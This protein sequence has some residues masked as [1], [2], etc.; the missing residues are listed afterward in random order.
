M[1]ARFNNNGEMQGSPVRVN[2]Q[3]GVAT[4]W[5]GDQPSLAIGEDG[6]VYVVW[7]VAF[8]QETNTDQIFTCQSQ[9]TAGRRFRVK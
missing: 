3:A 4:A 6:S 8:I 7:T 1:I 2:Q 5:R 9:T